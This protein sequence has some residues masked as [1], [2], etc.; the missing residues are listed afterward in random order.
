MVYWIGRAVWAFIACACLQVIDARADVI[1]AA[2]CSQQDVQK[3]IDAASDG[4][5][6]VAP[7]GTTAWRTLSAR[8]PA[9]LIDKKG[10]TL[11]GA[12]IDRTVVVDRTGEGHRET[13]LVVVGIKGKPFRIS[14]FTFRGMRRH[15]RTEPAID[16]VGDCASWRIDRCKFDATGTLG[17]GVFVSGYG[18]VHDCVFVNT[19]QGVA[20]LGDG[21]SSWKRP[22]TLGSPDAV[23][24]EDCTFTYDKRF[25]GALDAYNGARYVFRHNTVNG[26]GLG[27]HGCDSGGYRSTF[28]FEIYN[29]TMRGTG[30]AMHFRGGTGVVFDNALT[31][32]RGGIAVANY[33]SFTGNAKLCGKWGVC[34]GKNPLDGNQ[35][36]SGYPAL[37]QIGRSTN[38][39]LEPLY[40][41]GNTLDGKDINIAISIH[42]GSRRVLEHIKENRDF[43]NDTQRPG[44]MPYTYPHPLRQSAGVKH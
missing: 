20:V 4:D 12:G 32:Y 3:A 21:A 22:L 15:R 41:W 23:Y 31:G 42:G 39:T 34:D 6:V 24:V 38:Q 16:V 13:A 5:T 1:E 14:G 26:T 44:Y 25:D 8:T 36:P 35:D 2:S 11:Q 40:E 37:D 17:R 10:L 43:C 9:V 28:S 30:R 27:H 29:N 18:V 19:Y 7:A 33:R